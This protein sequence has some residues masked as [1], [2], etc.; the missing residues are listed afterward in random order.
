MTP[1]FKRLALLLSLLAVVPLYAK[2]QTVSQT[3]VRG[4]GPASAGQTG[5]GMGIIVPGQP[6][7]S[8]APPGAPAPVIDPASMVTLEGRVLNALT[9]QPLRQANLTIMVGWSGGPPPGRFQPQNIGAISD[10]AG[11]FKF[12]NLP[13][14]SYI[15]SAEKSGYVRQQYN[16]S[17]G[18][19]SGGP[20][21]V[22]S[23]GQ[24]IRDIE[25][26]LMPQGIVSG[27]VVDENGEP[28]A[29]APVQ[30]LKLASYFH[31]TVSSNGGN[32]DAVGGFLIGGLGPG[33]Y[34]IR[35]ENRSGVFGNAPA[36]AVTGR[37]AQQSYVP[38]FFPNSRTIDQAAT[39][40]LAAGQRVDALEIRLQRDQVF[41]VSGRVV[42]IEEQDPRDPRVQIS[43][44]S[45]A[46]GASLPPRP[47][48]QVIMTPDG[49]FE[50]RSVQPG[51]YYLIATQFKQNGPPQVIAVIPVMIV[52][53]DVD[54]LVIAATE[55]PQMQITGTVRLEGGENISFPVNVTLQP[56]NGVFFGGPPIS[57]GRVQSDG[58]F[59]IDNVLPRK[60]VVTIG[61]PLGSFVKQIRSGT[62]DVLT[63]GL[64]LTESPAAGPLDIV[65]GRNAAALSGIVSES[66]QPKARAYVTLFPDPMRPEARQLMRSAVSDAN[67]FFQLR[68]VAPG[69]YRLYAWGEPV[70]GPQLQPDDL[71]P[72]ES[73][74]VTITVNEGDE[75]QIDLDLIEP[76]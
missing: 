76:Q 39:I 51:A 30:V 40:T 63:N 27:T 56:V 32:S 10:A 16:P 48:G 42:G 11:N 24:A 65:I 31:R 55:T 67:G 41:S 28:V 46:S 44:Q 14:G 23:P 72:Y 5:A 34:I 47:L 12:E 35:A 74:S 26:K 52:N 3:A 18:Q 17:A 54:G 38:T 61:I 69:D 8:V 21:L 49:N 60:Y 2:G 53:G 73:G 43:L 4:I 59:H 64:D 33:K 15:L 68:G 22:G 6:S 29:N 71:K 57:P 9:G 36:P 70:Q 75:K 37:G 7:A 62:A 25:L 13:P 1:L 19:Q 58:S 66:D 45:Q 20:P 50:I